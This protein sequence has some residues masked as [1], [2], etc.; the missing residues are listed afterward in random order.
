[1]GKMGYDKGLIRY[2]TGNG[3]ALGWSR[4][5]MMRRAGRPRVLIYGALLIAVCVA[6]VAS[7]WQRSGLAVDVIRDRGA[8]ARIV[9]EGRVENVYRLQIMNRTERAQTLRIGV[10][11]LPGLVVG[12]ETRTTAEAN[13]VDAL[14]VRLALPPEAAQALVPGAHKIEFVITPEGEDARPVRESST[15]VIPR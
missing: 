11:G 1:M 9:D 8:L 15:F 14:S 2:A 6:F 5:Q 10:T 12:S 4:A 13:A 3:M 7:I